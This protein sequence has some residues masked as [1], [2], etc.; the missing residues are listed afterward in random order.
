M[1]STQ[2][3]YDMAKSFYDKHNGQFGVAQHLVERSL[4]NIKEEV[5]WSELNLPVIEDWIDNFLSHTQNTNG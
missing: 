1:F 3:G 5:H 2:E 4:R